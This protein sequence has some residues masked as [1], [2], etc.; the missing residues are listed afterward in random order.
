ML[1]LMPRRHTNDDYYANIIDGSGRYTAYCSHKSSTVPCHG[2]GSTLG[3]VTH[4]HASPT[5]IH[6]LNSMTSSASLSPNIVV[7]QTVTNLGREH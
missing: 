7:L 2:D 5:V 6:S 3:S 1:E 4:G